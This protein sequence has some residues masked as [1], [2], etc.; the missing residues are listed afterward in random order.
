MRVSLKRNQRLNSDLESFVYMAAHDLRSPLS[1]LKGLIYLMQKESKIEN[2]SSYYELLE[3]SVEKM[4]SNINETLLR[5]QNKRMVSISGP[6]DFEEIANESV[7]FLEN[8][9]GASSIS[10]SITGQDVGVFFS[11]HHILSSAFDNIISN[12]I[13]YQDKAK[14]SFLKIDINLNGDLCQISF[15]DNGIGID[16]VVQEKIFDKFYLLD[17][18]KGGSGLGLFIIKESIEKI[19]GTIHVRSRLGTGTVFTIQ[20]PNLIPG[21][22]L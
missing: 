20:I 9:E 7:N 4:N 18:S 6:I 17:N 3:K 19:G 12:A 10:L 1:S 16:N 8:M 5:L 11:D 2:L 14:E 13:H 22:K 21:L 15:H